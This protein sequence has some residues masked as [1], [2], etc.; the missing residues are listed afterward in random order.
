AFNCNDQAANRFLIDLAKQ[1]GGRFH[2]FSCGFEKQA[3]IEIPESEDVGG[4]KNELIR[5]EKELE[6]IAGLRDECLG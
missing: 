1:T 2:T 5:G 4:V 3:A 6:R